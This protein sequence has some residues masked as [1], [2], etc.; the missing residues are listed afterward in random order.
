MRTSIGIVARKRAGLLM[1]IPRCGAY[2]K[3]SGPAPGQKLELGERARYRAVIYRF[4][5]S[6]S[7]S[8]LATFWAA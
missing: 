2:G 4:T 1:A 6:S 3:Q 7:V 8:I 5:A